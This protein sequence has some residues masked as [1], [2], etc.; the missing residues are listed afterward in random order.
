MESSIHQSKIQ[1]A[2]TDSTCVALVAN[3]FD[4]DRGPR[5]LKIELN[6]FRLGECVQTR[7][8]TLGENRGSAVWKT[9]GGI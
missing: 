2:I 1:A 4:L 7:H 3:T 9:F 5:H 8:L 6:D